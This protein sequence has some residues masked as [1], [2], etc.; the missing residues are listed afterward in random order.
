MLLTKF[1]LDG[2]STVVK[3]GHESN[4]YPSILNN[5]SGNITDFTVLLFAKAHIPKVVTLFP[6]IV[7]GTITFCSDPAYPTILIVPSKKLSY[8]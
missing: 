3:L 4:A 6:S 8:L 7:L 2:I 5:P 1:K